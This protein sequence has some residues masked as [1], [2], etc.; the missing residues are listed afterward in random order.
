MKDWYT[1]Y[2]MVKAQQR[3][4][5]IRAMNLELMKTAKQNRRT[6]P[7][8]GFGKAMNRLGRFLETWGRHLQKR[9]QTC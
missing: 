4:E 5:E 6:D 2:K 7:V 3:E 1:I 8:P 9:Y